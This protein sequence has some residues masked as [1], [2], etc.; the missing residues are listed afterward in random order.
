M[1]IAHNVSMVKGDALSSSLESALRIFIWFRQ[2][3]IGKI[4]SMIFLICFQLG[5]K[6]FDRCNFA[7]LELS[8]YMFIPCE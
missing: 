8:G 4:N 2:S 6:V 3:N 5:A 1:N 7:C